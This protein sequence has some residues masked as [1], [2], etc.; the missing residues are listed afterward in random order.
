MGEDSNRKLDELRK[1]M[2]EGRK[3]EEDRSRRMNETM[4]KVWGRWGK[5]EKCG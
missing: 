1:E 5:L 2:R 3:K 4:E